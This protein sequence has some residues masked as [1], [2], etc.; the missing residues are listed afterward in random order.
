MVFIHWGGLYKVDAVTRW[1]ERCVSQK[2]PMAS[3]QNTSPRHHAQEGLKGSSGRCGVWPDGQTKSAPNV[4]H[5]ARQLL[6]VHHLHAQGS[7]CSCLMYKG[8]QP[9][10]SLEEADATAWLRV[11]PAEGWCLGLRQAALRGGNPG[12]CYTSS[13]SAALNKV[14]VL[15]SCPTAGSCMPWLLKA[16]CRS[17]CASSELAKPFT[18]PPS[19]YLHVPHTCHNVATVPPGRKGLLSYEFYGKIL[20]GLVC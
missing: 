20:A 16:S 8:F 5:G 1:Q 17:R 14:I 13:P 6:P 15:G 18:P 3:H 7:I 9:R 4:M 11:P 10:Y 12:E 19:A 2:W